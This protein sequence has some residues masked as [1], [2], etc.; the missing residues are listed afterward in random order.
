MGLKANIIKVASGGLHEGFLWDNLSDANVRAKVERA[1]DKFGGSVLGEGGEYETLVLDGPAGVWKGK[2]M[3]RDYERFVGRGQGGEAWLAF[4]KGGGEVVPKERNEDRGWREKLVVPGLWDEGWEE[5]VARIAD[6]EEGILPTATGSTNNTNNDTGT[7]WI[8]TKV[9]TTTPSTLGIFNLTAPSPT[10]TASEQ[11]QSII[12]THL[13]PLLA[14]HILPA[15]SIVFTTLLLRSM[16]DF[17]SLNE[18]YGALFH[19]PI[20]PARVTVACGDALPQGVKIMASFLMDRGKKEGREGLHV[21]SRSYW[22]P[23]NIGPYSQAIAVPLLLNSGEE[24]QVRPEVVYVAGQIPLVPASM[25]LIKDN[26]ADANAD[27]GRLEKYGTQ[28]CLALQHLWRIGKSMRVSC[29]LGGVAFIAPP[30]SSSAERKARLVWNAWKLVHQPD[31]NSQRSGE[32]DDVPQFDVWDRKFNGGGGFGGMNERE[33]E[34]DTL[35]P[36]WERVKS[37]ETV[38]GFF[39]VHVDQLPRGS[40]VEWQALG[41]RKCDVRIEPHNQSVYDQ[42]SCSIPGRSVSYLSILPGA[43]VREALSTIQHTQEITIYTSLSQFDAGVEA[44]DGAQI[45]P[46]KNVWG[47]EGRMLAAG[48]VVVAHGV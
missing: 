14:T 18:T 4:P 12:S 43:S 3:V 33:K 35:L 27:H 7:S 8:A 46:C 2:M 5:L 41:A 16:A 28:T 45:V 25:E 42:T 38:P 32:E 31:F 19:E 15:S 24:D 21:Q 34:K 44:V 39:A 6:E 47:R 10:S 20:P 48:V 37:E 17:V 30:S 22:A 36:D 40:E 1:V 23:A 29:W 13:I 26:S 9:T 11:M